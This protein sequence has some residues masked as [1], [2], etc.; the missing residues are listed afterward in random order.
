MGAGSGKDLPVRKVLRRTPRRPADLAPGTMTRRGIHA[1]PWT[2]PLPQVERT[3]PLGDRVTGSVSVGTATTGHLT[4]QR[5]LPAH[6]KHV[7]ILKEHQG[8]NTPWGTDELVELLLHAGERVAQKI[9]GSILM[10]GN[11]S[12]AGGGDM[13]WSVSH[14]SGRDVDLAYF[15]LD[16][17]GNPYQP[18]TLVLLDSKGKGV[19]DGRDVHFDAPRTWELVRALTGQSRTSV[20]Y[21]FAYEPLIKQMLEVAH[22]AGLTREQ[23]KQLR[24][25]LRQPKGAQ[26]HADHMHVRIACSAQDLALGC[27]DIVA[28]N[29]V[30]PRQNPDYVKQVE[31]LL[32]QVRHRETTGPEREAAWRTLGLMKAVVPK[33]L[34]LEALHECVDPVCGAL[35][36]A[37]LDLRMGL[38][39]EDLIRI[40]QLSD[41]FQAVQQACRRLRSWGP[42]AAKQVVPWLQS[43]RIVSRSMGP[44][45]QRLSLA[46]QA[47]YILGWSQS[48]AKWNID[49]LLNGLVGPDPAIRHAC[50]W[51]LSVIYG[52]PFL[53]TTDLEALPGPDLVPRFR[54]WARTHA[55]PSRNLRD[56]MQAKGLKIKGKKKLEVTDLLKAV[57][58]EDPYS[59]H[60]Q[61]LLA[62]SFKEDRVPDLRNKREAR[63]YWKMLWGKK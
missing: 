26:P 35:L 52:A 8:R 56:A 43:N 1:E 60:A 27:R 20:Q 44:F 5:R 61:R 45:R 62:E 42:K 48:R 51:A 39:V 41:D 3:H 25:V 24:L 50:H 32:G 54:A 19:V 53:T 46:E 18:T 16:A 22:K 21:V 15:V 31:S 58:L 4:G 63:R 17:S 2:L 28:G 23:E 7:R 14:N 10:V 29:E 57:E 59:F 55:D 11:L 33:P 47:A 30:L 40:A 36:D 49:A 13:P 37:A 6:G 9:P 12:K 34:F 38:P